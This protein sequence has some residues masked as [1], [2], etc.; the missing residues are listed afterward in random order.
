MKLRKWLLPQLHKSA[1]LDSV[2][3]T[4]QELLKFGGQ[5]VVDLND[6][7]E[8]VTGI[9]LLGPVPASRLINTTAPLTG[10]GNLSADRTL[11][12][13]AATAG[14]DGYMTAAQAAASH[15]AVTLANVGAS[16]NADGATLAGQQLQLQP[17]STTQPGVMTAADKTNL[18][19]DTA[20]RHAAVTLANVGAAP[21]A[22]G[23]SL[24]GQVLTLQP[25][26]TSHPGVMTA[27]DK[28]NLDADTAA[29]HAAVTLGTANGL[30]LSTQQL[31]LAAATASTPGASTAA[32][33]TL[34][35]ALGLLHAYAT[36]AAAGFTQGTAT[37]LASGYNNITSGSGGVRLP[38]P[39][40]TRGQVVVV[41][42]SSGSAKNVYPHS[43]GYID[44]A[45]VN[46]AFALADGVGATLVL[47]PGSGVWVSVPHLLGDSNG[48]SKA[49]G[50]ALAMAAA[51][52]G[53][54][55]VVTTGAQTFGGAKTFNGAGSFGSTL[56]VTGAFTPSGGIVQPAWG[57]LSTVLTLA[58]S[59]DWN[60][61]TG[62]N[63]PNAYRDREG[64]LQF[65]GR[66][67]RTGSPAGSGEHLFTLTTGN[68]PKRA[69]FRILGCSGGWCGV[70]IEGQDDANPGRVLVW[71]RSGNPHAGIFLSG[72]SGLDVRT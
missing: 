17:A 34:L 16:P 63:A 67:T 45:L 25:A 40:A 47:W 37:L 64:L 30:S 56:D 65:R 18:D 19:A 52:A 54:A 69:D 62:S 58:S 39:Q 70:S 5:V 46:T 13:P 14:N 51:G 31:S 6:L 43:G 71:E 36:V 4:V 61:G 8:Q 22:Q 23:A 21:N 68:V 49:A 1:K 44:N 60:A 29:R 38:A 20:A 12:M 7:Q 15:A 57:A 28:T 41:Y 11:A 2:I 50:G 24:S 32:Q 53:Q 66:I 26:S 59:P 35:E 3:T 33:V 42:N 9:N 55:G 48:L 72:L 27:A 10:G